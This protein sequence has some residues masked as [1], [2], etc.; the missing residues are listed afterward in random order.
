MWQCLQTITDYKGKHSREL[1]SDMSL[2]D[3]LNGYVRIEASNTEAFMSA[4]AVLDNYVITLSVAN[5]S[6]TF[7]LTRKCVP[8]AELQTF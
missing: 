3:E 4:S 1:L 6:Q 5:V 8:L 2:P 7:N